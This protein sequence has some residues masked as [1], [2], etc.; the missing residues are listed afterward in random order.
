VPVWA[1]PIGHANVKL[2]GVSVA[3][4]IG[5]LKMA[6]IILVLL[7]TP[8]TFG[9]GVTA[10]TVGGGPLGTGVGTGTGTGTGTG[11]E[12]PPPHPLA[13]TARSN[14]MNH[15]EPFAQPSYFFICFPLHLLQKPLMESTD[16]LRVLTLS[17]C[18]IAWNQRVYKWSISLYRK[19]IGAFANICHFYFQDG[20]YAHNRKQSVVQV[21]NNCQNGRA[22]ARNGAVTL[23]RSPSS[24]RAAAQKIYANKDTVTHWFQ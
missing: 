4:S 7:G 10:V 3:G 2:A 5:W 9:R 19:R 20:K 1:V 24:S 11:A 22:L 8:E 15:A 23:V 13:K 6:V 17:F 12:P 18:T 14:A 16:A 21:I